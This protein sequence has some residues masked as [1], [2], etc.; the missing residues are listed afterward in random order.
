MVAAMRTSD[1]RSAELR[2]QA[3]ASVRPGPADT[4]GRTVS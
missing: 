3:S 4:N 2:R 1:P